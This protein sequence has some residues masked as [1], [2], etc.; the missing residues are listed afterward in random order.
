MSEP[1]VHTPATIVHGRY[2]L[3][4]PAGDPEGLLVGFHG[5]GEDA[6]AHLEQLEKIP[7]AEA[8]ILC[9][10]QG[11]N[12]FYTRS[13]N[14]VASWMTSQDRELAID[15]NVRYVATVVAELKR[16]FPGVRRLVYLGF[17][18]GVAMAYRAA[19]GAGHAAEGLVVLAGDVPP[20]LADRPLPAF[21]RTLIG[22][23]RKEEW[24]SEEQL[25]NDVALLEGKGVEVT[26]HSFDGG[27]EWTDGFRRAVA[28]T[29]GLAG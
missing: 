1:T 3:R 11:L 28:E 16:R 8:W 23:G 18:Q 22:R 24:Y 9:A 29:F 6:R 20:E 19:A 4:E 25:A 7:G 14:V 27:H 26:V 10:V 21:P 15:D 5:Y 13:Q 17:S 12:R 2:F